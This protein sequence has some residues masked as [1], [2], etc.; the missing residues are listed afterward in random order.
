MEV[1][2][3]G[4]RHQPAGIFRCNQVPCPPSLA[5]GAE[6]SEAVA[7]VAGAS[8]AESLAGGLSVE[9]AGVSGEVVVG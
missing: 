3:I 8:V 7:S 4:G 2:L 6:A 5:G 9:A 1:E